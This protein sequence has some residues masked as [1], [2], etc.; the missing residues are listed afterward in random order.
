MSKKNQDVYGISH[1]V[2]F[3]AFGMGYNLAVSAAALERYV[4]LD[5]WVL[6]L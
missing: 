2:F 6:I 5:Y 1:R 4:L 3:C